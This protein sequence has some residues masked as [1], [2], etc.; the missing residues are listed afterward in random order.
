MR[1]I[2]AEPVEARPEA[3]LDVG[4]GFDQDRPPRLPLPPVHGQVQRGDLLRRVLLRPG[5]GRPLLADLKPS[6]F[7]ILI[8]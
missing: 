3:D 4:K 1:P 2:P 8:K 5:R 7:L 6:F